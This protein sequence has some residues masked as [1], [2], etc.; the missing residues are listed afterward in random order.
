MITFD[1]FKTLTEKI[2]KR[3]SEWVVLS[4]DGSEVL[5]THSTRE[6]AVKQLAA[7][8]ISKKERK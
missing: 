7:I 4:S 6:K 5:G 3:G 8:E 1:E 2:E